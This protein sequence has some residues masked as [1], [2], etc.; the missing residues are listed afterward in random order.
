MKN[1]QV[2]IGLTLTA[3]LLFGCVNNS[4]KVDNLTTFAKAY[5][6]VKYFHPSDEAANINWAKFSA[7]GAKE[8]EKCR[9]TEQV[10][11][12][13]NRLFSPI[14]PSVRFSVSQNEPKYDLKI[15]TPNDTAGYSLT[16]WQHQGISIDMKI[17]QPNAYKSVRVNKKIKHQEKIFEVQPQIGTTIIKNIG[18]E[19]Y[20]QIPQVLYC[21]E[22]G[23]Y[24]QADSI[25]LKK[26]KIDLDKFDFNLEKLA[27]RT[28][29]VIITYQCFSAFLSIL[30]CSEC[31]LGL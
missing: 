4:K 2:F 17:S 19:I 10:V 1:K 11:Q 29:N 15:I 28:G 21:N 22:K 30:R 14:A 25:S 8:I 27:L 24:P 6:Y 18:K 31:K 5:G 26:L 7:Y 20:C 13:L 23:T 12:T 3:L 9:S 16:Y